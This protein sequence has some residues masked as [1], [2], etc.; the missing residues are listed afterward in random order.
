[1]RIERCFEQVSRWPDRVASC[2]ALL[3]D[4]AGLEADS[5]LHV[6]GSEIA[7]DMD[8]GVGANDDLP[9]HNRQHFCEV[10]LAANYIGL[11]GRMTP[12]ERGELLLAALVHD[13]GHDGKGD[14]DEPFR[15]ERLALRLAQ[16]Y[17][18]RGQVPSATRQRIGAAVL[19]TEVRHGLQRARAWYRC[20]FMGDAV[21]E[22]PEPVTAFR[23]FADQPRAALVAVALAEADAIASVGLSRRYAGLQQQRLGREWGRVLGPREQSHYLDTIFG[24]FLVAR[25][26]APNL[27]VIRRDDC[28]SR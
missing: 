14:G 16:P 21:P 1:M 12:G 28:A 8:A 27:A 17:F 4:L 9:Y 3:A 25:F 10:M 7:A 6:A 13:F 18:S 5:P 20:H 11:L 23:V 19:A 26:F 24:E 2:F 22:G 15:L